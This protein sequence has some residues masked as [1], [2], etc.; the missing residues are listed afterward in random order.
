M[1]DKDGNVIYD[2]K[3]EKEQKACRFQEKALRH[4][5]ND[6]LRKLLNSYDAANRN[7]ENEFVHLYEIRDALVKFFEKDS[8][9]REKLGVSSKDWSLFGKYTNNGELEQSRH[10]G[11]H[12]G[13]HRRATS[14]ELA[15]V[16]NLAHQMIDK[17]LDY[18]DTQQ[19]ATKP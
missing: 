15:T 19:V 5:N 13:R 2:S 16:R 8:V 17:Y 6:I 4:L 11:M 18:L 7:P 10:R 3:I 9:A 14:E 12:L 1:L